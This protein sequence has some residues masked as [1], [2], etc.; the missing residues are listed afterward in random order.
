MSNRYKCSK[1]VPTSLLVKRLNELSDA[2][3]KGRL[4]H[5]FDMRIPAQ[6]ERDA[7]LVL[8]EAAKRLLNMQARIDNLML[9]FTPEEMTEVQ[10]REFALSQKPLRPEFAKIL[11]EN[12]ENLYI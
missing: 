7:D 8:Q 12:L 6:P 4:V 3:T 1:D 10:L 11:Y 2:V 9:E 5:E